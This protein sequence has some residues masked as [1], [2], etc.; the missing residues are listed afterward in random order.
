MTEPPLDP[1]HAYEALAKALRLF[2]AHPP[3]EQALTAVREAVTHAREV[4]QRCEVQRAT[5]TK[6]FRAHVVRLKLLLA[7]VYQTLDL[8]PGVPCQAASPSYP[9]VAPSLRHERH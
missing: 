1:Q 5:S 7:G 4:W 3:T 6:E 9:E 8:L 2:Y